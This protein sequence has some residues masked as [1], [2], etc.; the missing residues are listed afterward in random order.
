MFRNSND[1]C[2]P[3]D[4][5][6][7]VEKENEQ[8][9]SE[10]FFNNPKYQKA[11]EKWCAAVFGVGFNEYCKKCRIRINESKHHTS[12]DFFLK[13]DDQVFEFEMTERQEPDRKRGKY[14]KEIKQNS[15]MLTPNRPERGRQEGPSWIYQAIKKKVEKCYSNCRN[16]N[17]L[18]YANFDAHTMDRKAILQKSREF[19]DKFASIWIITNQH[20]CSLFSNNA[21]G[22]IDDFKEIKELRNR[23]FSALG[24]YPAQT[25]R[26]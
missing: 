7:A 13:I 11:Q 18:V 19:A 5:L 25:N 20:I 12:P 2:E 16:L 9:S 3:L 21:L 15:L 26:Q 14:Y 6:N 17:I 1:Y 4:L 22:E 8:V 10:I 24:L 23:F